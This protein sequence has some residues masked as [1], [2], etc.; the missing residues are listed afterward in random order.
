M[1][2]TVENSAKPFMREAITSPLRA[3]MP[4]QAA[5]DVKPS[6]GRPYNRSDRAMGTPVKSNLRKG[7]H[8][9]SIA[10]LWF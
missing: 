1:N 4:R 6:E 10:R 2:R 5:A 8:D 7:S 9:R 3:I